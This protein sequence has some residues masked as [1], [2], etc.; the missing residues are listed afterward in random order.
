MLS[1]HA[2]RVGHVDEPVETGLRACEHA[3]REL[4][5][6][7]V[8]RERSR[9]AEFR[10]PGCAEGEFTTTIHLQSGVLRDIFARIGLCRLKRLIRDRRIVAQYEGNSGDRHNEQ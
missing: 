2:F 6:T 5:A 4:D 1:L 9:L 8:A 7:V 10:E 3:R